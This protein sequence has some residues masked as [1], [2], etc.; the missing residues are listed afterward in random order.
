MVQ[1]SETMNRRAFVAGMA[2]L[3]VTARKHPIA[4]AAESEPSAPFALARTISPQTRPLLIAHNADTVEQIAA[5][6]A[7]GADIIEADVWHTDDGLLV[8]HILGIGD[9]TPPISIAEAVFNAIP[10]EEWLDSL[11]TDRTAM[12]DIKNEAPSTTRMVAQ[13]LNNSSGHQSAY[14]CSPYWPH[15]LAAESYSNLT[16]VYTVNSEEGLGEIFPLINRSGHRGLSIA[17]KL[18]TPEI[19]M[20]AHDLG[21]FVFV[22]TVNDVSEAQQFANLGVDGITTDLL[23]D[24]L[25]ALAD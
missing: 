12:F 8:S 17:K 19:V 21:A 13:A 18:V 1:S 4:A 9:W 6:A 15:I 20:A 11:P 14:L 22:W 2:L 24:L 16:G 23:E 7:A 5:S 3:G 10:L 25:A